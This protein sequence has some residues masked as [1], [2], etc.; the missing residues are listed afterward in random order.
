[1]SFETEYNKEVLDLWKKHNPPNPL[2]PK[3]IGQ[4]NINAEV[5]FVGMNPSFSESKMDEFFASEDCDNKKL[6]NQISR[7]LFAWEG[8]DFD[9]RVGL[10]REYEGAANNHTYNNY[11]G[12]FDPFIIKCGYKTKCWEHLDLFIMRGTTQNKENKLIYDKNE[13][14][15]F[16]KDQVNLFFKSIKKTNHKLV[17][18]FNS[19]ASKIIY[20]ELKN[21]QISDELGSLNDSKDI[22]SYIDTDNKRYYF[23]SMLTSGRLDIFSRQRL[24]NE[25]RSF[26]KK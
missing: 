17:I 25:I 15:D 26:S 10:I 5:L 23:S 13:L 8:P 24:I 21:I 20:K 16:G 12:L 1:M 14:N 11:F 7:Q 2:I 4:Y 6:K 9:R 18:V 22:E 19:E 3:Q